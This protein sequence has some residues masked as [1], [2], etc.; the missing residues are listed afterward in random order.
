M[1]AN[2]I[3]P[4]ADRSMHILGPDDDVIASQYEHKMTR[5]TLV[6]DHVLLW[7]GETLL[8]A[9][10][11]MGCPGIIIHPA[12]KLVSIVDA[13]DGT[14]RARIFTQGAAPDVKQV[15]MK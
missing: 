4:G 1:T 10:Y 11:P 12:F 6:G 7:H 2:D 14:L 8:G 13:T 9:I 5:F 3:Q 15:T